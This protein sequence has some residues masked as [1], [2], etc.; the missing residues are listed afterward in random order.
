VVKAE[1]PLA[2]LL[3]SAVEIQTYQ[4]P[5]PDPTMKPLALRTRRTITEASQ[6]R[7]IAWKKEAYDDIAAL[8]RNGELVCC[9]M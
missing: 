1:Q 4:P 6:A 3:A 7:H 9:D 8:G 5:K 2:P